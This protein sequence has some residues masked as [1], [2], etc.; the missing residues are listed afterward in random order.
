[1][2]K[3]EKFLLEGPGSELL[4]IIKVPFVIGHPPTYTSNLV[5]MC[6]RVTNLPTELNYLDSFKSYCNSSDLGFL[7]SGGWGR[8]VG[9]SGVISYSLYEFRNFRGKESSN[10]IELSRLVQDLLNFG[11]LGSLWLWG[12]GGWVDSGWGVPLHM[13]HASARTHTHVW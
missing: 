8:W 7:G 10:R 4:C 12:W 11:V 5:Y 2:Q 1:M 9:V 6:A 3:Q 13:L